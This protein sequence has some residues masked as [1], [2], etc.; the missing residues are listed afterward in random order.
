MTFCYSFRYIFT[1]KLYPSLCKKKKKLEPNL[2]LHIIHV[3]F[4]NNS[5]EYDSIDTCMLDG[6]DLGWVKHSCSPLKFLY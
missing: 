6:G 3:T 4:Y 1:V 2:Y 5:P